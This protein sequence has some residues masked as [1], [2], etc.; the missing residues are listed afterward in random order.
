MPSRLGRVYQLLLVHEQ[1]RR[2]G[3]EVD[4]LGPLDDLQPLDGDVLLVGQAEADKVEHAGRSGLVS[5]DRSL[6]WAPG[7]GGE[8]HKDE[9]R[10]TR[11]MWARDA[12]ESLSQPSRE[13]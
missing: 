13:G 1:D 6:R 2:I 7:C 12:E 8:I 5:L 3:F 11:K 10:G 4:P 9:R